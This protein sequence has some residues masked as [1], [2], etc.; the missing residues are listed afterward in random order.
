MTNNYEIK[1]ETFHAI[2]KNSLK[3]NYFYI[4]I[5]NVLSIKY[6]FLDY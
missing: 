5:E 4:Y 2:D 3:W 1:F 6:D